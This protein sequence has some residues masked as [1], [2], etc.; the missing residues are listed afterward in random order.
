MAEFIK[1][2]SEANRMCNTYWHQPID[3]ACKACPAY[4]KNDRYGFGECGLNILFDDATF[5]HENFAE[6]KSAAEKFESIVM[7]WSE[8]DY[9]KR[10]SHD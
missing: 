10:G 8:E 7:K 6:A 1:V 3:M 9:K 4:V 5:E 2:I